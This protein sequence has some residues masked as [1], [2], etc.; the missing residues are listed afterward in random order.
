MGYKIKFDKFFSYSFS[1]DCVIFGFQDGQIKVL[2]IKRAMEP[3][4]GSWAIP[5][6]L[7]YPEEDLPDAATRILTELTSV[8]D[9][10]L[11]QGRTFGKP[12]RH[13]QGRVI[14]NAY[15]ALVKID[16]IQAKAASWADELKWVPINEVG[17][18]A[19]D[20]NEVLASTYQILKYKLKREPVCFDLLPEKFALNE[21]QQLFEYAF[22]ISM[23]KANFRKK[24]KSI[25]LINLNVKQKNVN[26]RPANLFEFDDSAY[27]EQINE[28]N[29]TFKM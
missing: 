5:G 20:H 4:L 27:E 21:M 14:T 3:Y 1:L 26:H 28:G 2:L 25:P 16:D 18:L 19:F 9:V 8:E 11:H 10:I 22:D 29:Y 12:D 13:P 24:I 7:L 6:D 15:F 23:D 17:E